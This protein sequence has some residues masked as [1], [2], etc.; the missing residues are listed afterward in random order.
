MADAKEKE[1]YKRKLEK[2][3][4]R[5]HNDE[6]YKKSILDNNKRWYKNHRKDVD[7]RLRRSKYNRDYY[8]RKKNKKAESNEQLC[9]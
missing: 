4:E 9:D 3:N 1:W 6:E 5:Y 8:I 7:F 2:Q